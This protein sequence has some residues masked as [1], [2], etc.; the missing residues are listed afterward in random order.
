MHG[1]RTASGT[2]RL[3][4]L[5]TT[6]TPSA[7]ALLQERLRANPHAHCIF[8]PLDHLPFVQAFLS[9]W[10]PTA[11][12][13]VESELWPNMILEAAKRKMP[14]G[15]VNG[16]MSATSFGRWNSWL[17]RRLAQHLLAPFASLTLCQSPEDLYRFQALGV[18]SA[19]YVGDLKF[20]SAK[21]AVNAAARA[22]LED[23]LQGR[24]VWVAVSTHDGEEAICVRAHMEIRRAHPGALLL[25]IPRHPHRCDAIQDGIHTTTPLRTQRRAT[26]STPKPDTDVFIVDVIGETQLYFDVSPIAFVG[27][28]L[29]DVGGHNVLEPLRSGCAVLHGP[30]MDNCTSVL[31]TLATIAAPIHCVDEASLASHVTRLLSTPTPSRCTSADATAPVQDAL[32]AALAPFLERITQTSARGQSL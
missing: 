28:S 3:D 17:G 32:W 12:I 6:T 26:D 21:Q 4:V 1:A 5:L 20:L 8:A 13:W 18:T 22:R 9:T 7:R 14:M 10:Q 15:L 19:K 25:L 2:Q 24:C 11:A 16:R 27:G 31:A 30:H 29:V 23:A